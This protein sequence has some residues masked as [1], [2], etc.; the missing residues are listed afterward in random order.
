MVNMGKNFRPP[1]HENKRA[2]EYWRLL[3]EHGFRFNTEGEAAFHRWGEGPGS[4]PDQ[5][6]Q[7]IAACQ[8]H[9]R[10]EGQRLLRTIARNQQRQRH[11]GK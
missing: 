5:A 11:R 10:T 2:W 3:A 9:T 8:C 6:Q 7:V 4:G 1:R